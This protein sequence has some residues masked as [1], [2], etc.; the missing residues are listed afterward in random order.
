[1]TFYY[2]AKM[3]KKADGNYRVEYFDLDECYG[4][5]PT[6][7]EALADAR[8]AAIDWIQLE[9]ADTNDL[10]GVTHKD[11]IVLAPH[12]RFVEMMIIMPREGWD[13]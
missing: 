11:D 1:M 6:E 10:P 7:D 9:L 4:E 13:E 12:E 2:P 3:F 8:A 5:G